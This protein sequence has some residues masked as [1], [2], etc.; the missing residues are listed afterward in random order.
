MP[1]FWDKWKQPDD[2]D[3]PYV[4]FPTP[5]TT[6]K[7]IITKLGSTDFGGREA[8]PVPVVHLK[9][10][11][12]EKILNAS[13]K[14]LLSKLAERCPEVGDGL[15]VTYTGDAPNALPGRN[16]A[17]LFDVR[18]VPQAMLGTEPSS[19]PPPPAEEPVAGDDSDPF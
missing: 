13:Q 10:K 16:P 2:A 15:E 4:R 12:G 7:G 6:I 1:G 14:V 8:T 5:G 18:V 19:S 11:S 9:T 3:D 17:K